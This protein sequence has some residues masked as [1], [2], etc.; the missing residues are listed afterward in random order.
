MLAKTKSADGWVKK[1][2]T[3]ISLTGKAMALAGDVVFVAGAPIIFK[4]D[5]LAATYE[6]RCGGVLWAASASD[7][8]KLAQYMLDALP[9]WDSMAAAYGR[10]FIANQDGSV[11]CWGIAGQ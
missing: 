5:D 7:G 3:H 9:A 1:W 8:S 2:N 10:L 4:R 11:D 6:G